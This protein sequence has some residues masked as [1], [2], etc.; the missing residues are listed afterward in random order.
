MTSSFIS[1]FFRTKDQLVRP[2]LPQNVYLYSRHSVISG[3]DWF[4]PYATNIVIVSRIVIV[5][6]SSMLGLNWFR[7]MTAGPDWMVLLS[8]QINQYPPG[9]NVRLLADDIY[10]CIIVNEKFCILIKI[11]LKFFSLGPNWQ[12][13]S[14]GLDNGLAPNRRQAI[15]WTNVGPIHWRIYAALGGDELINFSLYIKLCKTKYTNV[16]L[17]MGVWQAAHI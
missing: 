2:L 4:L 13:P 16:C 5:S 6:Y 17:K 12:Q 7:L 14:T 11:S 10:R 15:I 1:A 8:N 9:Q 3:R